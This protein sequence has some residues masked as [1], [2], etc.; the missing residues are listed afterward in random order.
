[1]VLANVVTLSELVWPD[2]KPLNERVGRELKR[3]QQDPPSS[4]PNSVSY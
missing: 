1:L 4:T 2:D 3:L